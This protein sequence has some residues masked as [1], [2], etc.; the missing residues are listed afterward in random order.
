M[1]KRQSVHTEIVE[2][3]KY[4]LQETIQN[5]SYRNVADKR[6]IIEKCLRIVED[7]HCLHHIK[8]PEK[9]EVEAAQGEQTATQEAPVL[10]EE[11]QEMIEEVLEKVKERIAYRFERKIK[12]GFIPEIGAFVPERQVRELNLSHGDLVY[13]EYLGEVEDGPPRY[14]FEVAEHRGGEDPP[15][16]VQMNYCIVE[17]DPSI[18]R[19]VVNKTAGG[20]TIKIDDVPQTILLPQEDCKELNIKSGDIVDIAYSK[21]NTSY[22]RIIW[23]YSTD[24]EI[25]H[26][27]SPK[28]SSYYKKKR[29]TD[30]EHE[31]EIEPVF[32]GKTICM[33]GFEP[34][35]GEFRD[36]VE[37][38][39]G[40]FIW[41]SGRESA[42]ELQ[43]ALRKSDAV[44]LM[45]SH[46]GHA[47]TIFAADFCKKHDIPFDSMHGFGRSTFIRLAKELIEKNE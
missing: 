31:E 43:A 20:D 22:V 39:G 45:L 30:T 6:V 44:I 7:S 40:E 46:V 24:E 35:R 27:S 32:E 41:L 18:N 29:E 34:G 26:A 3:M 47:G 12:G 1:R 25:A 42:A 36:E 28:P 8:I 5:I 37:K 33:M 4:A 16:R 19:Y 23:R 11:H 14:A 2:L 9:V 17:Y 21:N 38:R 10:E 15:E 13:A